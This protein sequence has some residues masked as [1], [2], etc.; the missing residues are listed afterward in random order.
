MNEEYEKNIALKFPIDKKVEKLY[1]GIWAWTNVN[2]PFRCLVVHYSATNREEDWV[3]RKKQALSP[4]G[5]LAEFELS[6]DVVSE[7]KRVFPN[8]DRERHIKDVRL[9]PNLEVIRS[10]D[11]G[12]LHS[13]VLFAQKDKYGQLRILE[14]VYC[15][16]T[17][18]KDLALKIIG[19]SNNRYKDCVFTDVCD[20]KAGRQRSEKSEKTNIDILRTYNIFARPSVEE[21]VASGINKIALLLEKKI[22]K[23]YGLVISHNCRLLIEGFLGGYVYDENGEPEKEGVYSHLF[24]CL[25]YIVVSFYSINELIEEVEK[26]EIET[27]MDKEKLWEKFILENREVHREKRGEYFI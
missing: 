7:G 26:Q 27:E 9:E 8:F 15:E 22:G 20:P 5:F 13:A 4:S 18:T 25:R 6:F 24:D 1:R 23:E 10:W 16:N 14:E 19:I 12:F 11:F 2:N 17:Y 21:P 3:K